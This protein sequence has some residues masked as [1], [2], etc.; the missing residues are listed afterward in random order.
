MKDPERPGK[1][2]EEAEADL[3][4]GRVWGRWGRRD[5]GCVL[6][7]LDL[8]LERNWELLLRPAHCI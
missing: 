7:L 5:P 2:E 4:R 6:G 3:K 1:S 8:D